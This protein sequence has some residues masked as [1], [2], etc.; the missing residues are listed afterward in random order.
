MHAF[1]EAAGA[2][3]I[4]ISLLVIEVSE[5]HIEQSPTTLVPLMV[6]CASSTVLLMRLRANSAAQCCAPGANSAAQCCVI[7]EAFSA[8]IGCLRE[9]VR[10]YSNSETIP[11]NEVSKSE[12]PFESFQSHSARSRMHSL[13]N[14][15]KHIMTAL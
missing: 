2:T 10:R 6:K 5:P 12:I 1:I 8:T 14:I 13:A 7:S 4:I 15:E 3:T 9:S 11:H